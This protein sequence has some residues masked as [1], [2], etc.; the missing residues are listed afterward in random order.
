MLR[1]NHFACRMQVLA[2]VDSYE[3]LRLTLITRRHSLGLPQIEVDAISG[4][5]DGYTAKLERGSKHLGDVSLGCMLGALGLELLVVP[6]AVR[7][8]RKETNAVQPINAEPAR[9]AFDK[10]RQRYRDMGRRSGE[11]RR[12]RCM[13]R[14]AAG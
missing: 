14:T 11:T 3:A 13:E 7:H 12:A 1:L 5:Q 4:L 6:K 9:T 10:L 8:L 2:R